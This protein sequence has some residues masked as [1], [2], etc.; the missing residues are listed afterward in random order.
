VA[1]FASRQARQIID[2]GGF[3]VRWVADLMYDGERRLANIDLSDGSL[4]LNWDGGRFVEG[5]GEARI[6]WTDEFGRDGVPRTVGDWFAPFGA[7]LQVDCIIGAGVFSERIPQGRFLIVD[8]PDVVESNVL[9]DGRVIHPGQSF[10]VTLKDR[11][12]KVQRD[13]FPYP[14]ASHSTSAWE[15]AQ[16]LTGLPV[17]KNVADVLVPST[18]YDGS[19]EDAVRAIFDRLDAWPHLDS[20]GALTARPKAWGDV[21]GEFRNVIS[22]PLTLTSTETYNRVVVVGKSPDGQPLYGVREVR[23]GFLR[24]VNVDGSPSPFG[25]ATYKYPGE[26]L[27]TQGEVDGYANDLLPRVARLR[28]RK[29]V[30]TESFNPLREV[31]DVMEFSNKQRYG[32]DLVRI[33]S[34]AHEGEVTRSTVEVADD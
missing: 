25:G 1:R 15:E 13:V 34:I 26:K 3:T 11:L 17:V 10:G 2:D 19:R 23:S 32:T 7:E 24:T 4:S 28:T 6:V 14:T 12:A 29:R 18:P 27:S 33:V 9:F 20:T 8:V 22:A 21:S 30:V 5:S 16:N 31:G